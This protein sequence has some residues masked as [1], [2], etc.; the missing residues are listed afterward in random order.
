M[1]TAAFLNIGKYK[2]KAGVIGFGCDMDI[3]K[4]IINGNNIK[5][6]YVAN[7]GRAFSFSSV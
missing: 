4:G 1:Y 7:I 5:G 3:I 2:T 6:D